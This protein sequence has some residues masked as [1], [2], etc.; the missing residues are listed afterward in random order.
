MKLLVTI[1][2]DSDADGVT[3]ALTAEDYRVTRIA[4]TG[5]FL[6]KGVVTLLIGLEEARVDDAIQVIRT[7][8]THDEKDETQGTVFVLPVQNFTQV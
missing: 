8:V 6:R 1:I 4:S 3:Q 5:G 7:N 2:R